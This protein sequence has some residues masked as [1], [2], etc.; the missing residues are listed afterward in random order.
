MLS[1]L[2][3]LRVNSSSCY[4]DCYITKYFGCI[5]LEYLRGKKYW[6][7]RKKMVNNSTHIQRGDPFTIFIEAVNHSPHCPGLQDF[8]LAKFRMRQKF[9][10]V[11]IKA[12]RRWMKYPIYKAVN[13]LPLSR[14]CKFIMKSDEL[15]VAFMKWW[16]VH[17]FLCA[18][19]VS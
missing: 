17:L 14:D 4:R 3:P 10:K 13:C 15:F 16:T 7:V 5:I 18:Y 9:N 6:R 2:S 11:A 8:E 12:K 1:N 19:K